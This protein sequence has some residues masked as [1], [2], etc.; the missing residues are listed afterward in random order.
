MGKR[1]GRLLNRAE[2]RVILEQY[3]VQI[4]GHGRNGL[5]YTIARI[6]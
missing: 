2:D 4:T 6:P 3:C 1:L 5:T